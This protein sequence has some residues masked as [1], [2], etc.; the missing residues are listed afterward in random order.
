MVDTNRR[1]ILGLPSSKDLGL[2]ILYYC[3]QED[4]N[5]INNIKDLIKKY[6]S[7][8]DKIRKFTVNYHKNIIK[9]VLS[10]VNPP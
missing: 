10:V 1:A 7:S 6:K 5:K 9:D 8:F 4:P 3:I 2:V